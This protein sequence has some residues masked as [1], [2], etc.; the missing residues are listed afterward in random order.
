MIRF[1]KAVP[2][3]WKQAVTAEQNFHSRQGYGVDTGSGCFADLAAMQVLTADVEKYERLKQEVNT[4]YV[5][6]IDFRLTDLCNIFVFPSGHGDGV[7][8]CYFGYDANGTVICLATDFGII[9]P[10][11]SEDA[12]EPNKFQLKLDF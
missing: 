2:K 4:P 6:W 5:K 1:S 3:V 11:P 12:E 8:P 10:L 7:Y 9:A